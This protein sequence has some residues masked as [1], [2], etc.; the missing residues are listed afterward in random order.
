MRSSRDILGLTVS[1]YKYKYDLGQLKTYMYILITFYD[2]P[3]PYDLVHVIMCC[4]KG[5]LRVYIYLIYT[6]RT[7]YSLWIF[8]QKEMTLNLNKLI[9]GLLWYTQITQIKSAAM[10]TPVGVDTLKAVEIKDFIFTCTGSWR[11]FLLILPLYILYLRPQPQN[12]IGYQ[13][14]RLCR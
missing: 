1:I 8:L 9:K 5:I 3:F 11:K 2:W 12:D 14:T 4:M 7:I 10:S 6:S 13:N